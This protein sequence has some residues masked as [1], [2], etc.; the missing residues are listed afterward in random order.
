MSKY[1][2]RYL[3]AVGV[4]LTLPAFT[5]GVGPVLRDL[6]QRVEV[7]ETESALLTEE[8]DAIEATSALLQEE[9]EALEAQSDGLQA[10]VGVLAEE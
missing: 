6:I 10:Q 3:I 5:C 2:L 7:L 1:K 4:L 8:V 9:V